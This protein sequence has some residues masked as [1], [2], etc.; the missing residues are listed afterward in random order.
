MKKL[1]V[2]V[3]GKAYDVLVEILDEGG[4]PAPV[5]PSAHP[6]HVEPAH[7][8][9]P[10]VSARSSA[11]AAAPGNVPS[12][13]AGKVVSIDVKPGQQVEANA[14]LLTLEAMKMNTYVFAPVGGT[15]NEILVAPGDAVEE[16]QVLVKMS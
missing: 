7:V 11:G 15:V 2:T 6:A 10:P 9:A 1:R 12:P 4:A 3:D 13:L 8:S 16:G 14:Q 5:R